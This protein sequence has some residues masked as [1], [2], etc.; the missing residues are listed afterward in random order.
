MMEGGGGSGPSPLVP[1]FHQPL[2]CPARS[3]RLLPI[4]NFGGIQS[5][6]ERL[7]HLLFAL[8]PHSQARSLP[9][10]SSAAC[11]SWSRPHFR[12]GEEQPKTNSRLNQE[13]GGATR[14]AAAG[15][16]LDPGSSNPWG[17]SLR[18]T[19]NTIHHPLTDYPPR[20]PLPP[21]E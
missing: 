5:A 20:A 3:F 10:I 8:R 9:S 12:R 1:H 18:S 2:M 16:P 19:I 14:A 21:P 11:C 6:G 13:D 4:R 7:V 15:A 17:G